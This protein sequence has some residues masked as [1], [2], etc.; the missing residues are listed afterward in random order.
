M[1]RPR[2]AAQHRVV[3]N[4]RSAIK[5]HSSDAR[6]AIAFVRSLP[7]V[8]TALVGMRSAKHLNEN[9]GAGKKVRG[10]DAREK[11]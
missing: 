7:V 1:M 5:G 9:L 11:A 8:T 4:W 2:E 6:R 10:G 3:A